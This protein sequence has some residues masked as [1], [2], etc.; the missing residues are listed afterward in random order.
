MRKK[1]FL[2][3][4]LAEGFKVELPG[5][6]GGQI[7]LAIW[8]YEHVKGFLTYAECILGELFKNF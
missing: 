2:S 5:P 1:L 4:F 8:G 7:Q 3:E 6:S